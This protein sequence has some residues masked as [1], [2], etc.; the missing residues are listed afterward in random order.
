MMEGNE[1]CHVI[2]LHLSSIL[3]LIY[4][5]DAKNWLG[6]ITITNRFSVYSAKLYLSGAC[7]FTYFVYYQNTCS[8]CKEMIFSFIFSFINNV[9]YDV[10][11][12]QYDK[13]E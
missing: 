1:I 11:Y 2:I 10:E 3:I 12:Q 8:P 7:L 9:V 5:Q 13:I 4:R 6:G